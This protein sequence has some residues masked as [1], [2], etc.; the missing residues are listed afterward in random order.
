[1][2]LRRRADASVDADGV[3]DVLDDA[4]DR[5]EALEA[6]RDA[7]RI[8]IDGCGC[9]APYDMCPHDE[10]LTSLLDRAERTEAVLVDLLRRMRAQHHLTGSYAARPLLDEVD[11]ALATARPSRPAPT[12]EHTP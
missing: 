8:Q 12:E 2:D 5:I 6:E 7:L 10:P 3:R 1:M 11:A 9:P 4:L